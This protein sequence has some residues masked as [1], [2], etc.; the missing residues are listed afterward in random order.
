MIGDRHYSLG[1][2][3]LEAEGQ[4][5]LVPQFNAATDD[6]PRVHTFKLRFQLIKKVDM[7]N[8]VVIHYCDNIATGATYASVPRNTHTLPFLEDILEAK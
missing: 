2:A 4:V 7:W 1:R 8:H 6:A 5:R 3:C